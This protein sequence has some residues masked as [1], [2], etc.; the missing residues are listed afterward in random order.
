MML[1]PSPARWFELL[2]DREHLGHVLG[3]LADT[4]SVQLEAYSAVDAATALPDYSRVLEQFRQLARR[5]AAYWPQARIDAAAAAARS[6][7][8]AEGDLQRLQAWAVEADPL[9]T[10]LQQLEADNAAL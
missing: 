6:V 1:R 5:Y 10:R 3:C 9:I 4:G 2:T 7:D 8:A